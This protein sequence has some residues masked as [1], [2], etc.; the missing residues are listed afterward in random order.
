M[1]HRILLAAMVCAIGT[2]APSLVEAQ[3]NVVATVPDLA[4]IANAV[5]GD[6]VEVQTLASARQDPHF[7]DARPSYIVALNGA[8]ALLINGLELEVGWLPSLQ[9]SARNSAINVGGRGYFDASSYVQLMGVPATLDRS[10]GDVHPGG[11]P[12][13]LASPVAAAA[14][15]TALGEHF[16]ALD[17]TNA[18]AF[19]QSAEAFSTELTAFA[20]EQ[21]ARFDALPANHRR[22]VAYHDSLSYLA[23]WLGLEQIATVEPLPGV[24]PSPGHIA[25]VLTAMRSGDVKVII[26]E[27]YYP[28]NSS[29]TLAE[30]ASGQVVV[31][32]GGTRFDE[33]QTYLDRVQELAD[34]LYTAL[35]E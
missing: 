25:E 4:A 8:D 24:S 10:R 21:R 12:H 9:S 6:L 30:L 26:Q 31:V 2:A 33:S 17:P 18:E 32:K 20:T 22:F 7:V 11:N 34:S 23:D 15:A 35:S 29:Q 1:K 13:F 19:R 5:G 27:E 16:A 3:L 14:V 28:T